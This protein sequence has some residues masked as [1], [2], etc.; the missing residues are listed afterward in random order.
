MC[1]YTI[2][3]IN[4]TQT[5]TNHKNLK[6]YILDESSKIKIKKNHLPPSNEPKTPSKALKM[7]PP[8]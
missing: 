8:C 6:Q 4:D 7:N 1:V 5:R 2:M 3:H